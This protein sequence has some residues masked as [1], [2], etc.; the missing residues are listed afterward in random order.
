MKSRAALLATGA[1]VFV[2]GLF[3]CEDEPSGFLSCG[4]EICGPREECVGVDLGVTCACRPGYLGEACDV[5]APGYRRTLD[6]ECELIPI[7]CDDDPEVC[8]DH[9]ECVEGEDDDRCSCDDRSTG[10]F[11]DRC[12]DDYQDNDLDGNCEPTCQEADLDCGVQRRCSDVSGIPQCVCRTGFAGDTCELCAVGYRHN[13]ATCVATCETAELSCS[14]SEVCDDG[15]SPPRCVC[16]EGYTGAS[17]RTCA[18]GYRRDPF[19]DV[20]LPSCEIADLDCGDRG[21]CSDAAGF[22][23]CR[24]DLGYAG[25]ACDRCADGYTLA[26]DGTCR[27]VPPATY[28]LLAD[29]AVFGTAELVALDPGIG[30]VISVGEQRFVGLASG[31]TAGTVFTLR[32]ATILSLDLLT[33]EESVVG[34]DLVVAPTLALDTTRD[35]L[36][37]IRSSGTAELLVID[38]E[39]GV[40]TDV[41]E[42]GLRAV[43]DLAYDAANDR[44][45]VLSEGLAA[46]DPET[47]AVTALPDPP[48]ATRGIAF[49]I[50]GTLYALAATDLTPNAARID[51]CRRS[52]AGLGIPGYASAI[53]SVIEPA[54]SDD[55]VVVGSSVASRAEVVAYYGRGVTEAERSVTIASEN[56]QAVLCLE[57]R[58]STALTIPATAIFRALVVYT[59]ASPISVDLEPD[60]TAPNAPA[61]HLGAVNASYS[62]PVSIW[63]EEYGNADWR[64][65]ELPIDPRFYAPGPGVLH[66][67]DATFAS[68]SA[69]AL[70]SSVRPLGSLTAWRPL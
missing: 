2:N 46:V 19:T 25:V 69:T 58:E 60:F 31:R 18:E 54:P 44:L 45:L 56:E 6:A 4:A 15:A 42:T 14:S 26:M 64:D 55:S 67:L 1:V 22:A 43:R 47:A 48:P 35:R 61:I 66:V 10:R 62:A 28:T 3:A 11:C 33:G 38:P 17:C 50:D 21:E 57:I 7:D 34:S 13:G 53:G 30:D 23:S 40:A 70:P 16:R 59:A 36:Y 65:L 20:C 68:T 32:G 63:I 24:C 9:G 52:A 29:A 12:A 8:G 27:F 37:A 39:G 51:V 49:D 5:C 41:G